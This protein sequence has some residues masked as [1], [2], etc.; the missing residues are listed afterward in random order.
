[1]NRYT[2]RRQFIQKAGALTCGVAVFA[3][4]ALCF[5][6]EGA[7]KAKFKCGLP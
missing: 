3:Q 5:A 6:R 7:I 1:M 4:P 2:T